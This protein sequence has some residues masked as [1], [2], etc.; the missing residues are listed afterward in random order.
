MLLSPLQNTAKKIGE[1][2]LQVRPRLTQGFGTNIET[3]QQ[4]GLSG[5]DGNDFGSNG[6]DN[7]FAPMQGYVKVKDSVDKG[8]GLHIKLRDGTKELVLGHFSQV[9]VQ[10]GD[11]VHFGDKIAVMGNSGFSSA[12]HLHVGLRFLLPNIDVTDFFQLSIKNYDNG[13]FGYV[14]PFSYFIWWKGAG[15][16]SSL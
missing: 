15:K 12:K 9:F 2:W 14:D 7:I 5:H 4:F 1:N 3:Y 13:F 6:D 16:A 11:Y 8:Y 10:S